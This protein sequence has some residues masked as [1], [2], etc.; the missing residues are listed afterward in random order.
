VLETLDA[1]LNLLKDERAK[2]EKIAKLI[3]EQPDL[4][5][6]HRDFAAEAWGCIKGCGWTA[7]TGACHSPRRRPS[8]TRLDS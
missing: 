4:G 6:P 3:A 8:R 2:A 5:I 7:R 1:Y